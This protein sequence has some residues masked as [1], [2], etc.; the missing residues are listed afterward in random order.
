[1]NPKPDDPRC[2]KVLIVGLR[3]PKMAREYALASL[4]ELA[5]LVDTAGGTVVD[6]V[7][8]ELREPSPATL[9]GK[10]KVDEIAGHVKGVNADVVI[11]DDELTPAQ[12]RNLNEA[13]GVKVL[14]RTAL[15]LDI[16][17][18]RAHTKEGKLQV[19]LAQ[20]EYR[21]PRLAGE[22]FAMSQQAGY[23]GNRGPG[24]TKLEVDRR[25]LRERITRL[26]HDLKKVMTHR[27]IHRQK[28]EGVPIPTISLVGYTNAGK[29]TLLNKLTNADVFVEDKLFATLDPTVRR[30]TLENGREILVADTVGFIRRLPHQLVDSF[31]AT[32]EEVSRSN[33]LLHIVDVSSPDAPEQMRTVTNVLDELGLGK[34][35]VVVVLNKCDLP[36]RYVKKKE[37]Y[38][39][40]SACKG[41]GIDIL[42]NI[43]GDLLSDSFKSV[44]MKI[45]YQSAGILDTL[46]RIGNVRKIIKKPDFILLTVDIDNKYIGKYSKYILT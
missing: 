30:L 9:I 37:G 34:K 1:M 27:E 44:E 39:E 4:K 11:L 38:V 43:V 42:L 22:G 31:K 18:K 13:F 40:I 3:R 8:Q 14:D 24:E 19:E 46:Y 28:R 45:P 26:R 36:R 23:I 15:I 41:S 21:L 29:S 10:G 33:L 17:A 5:S 7:W 16:F 35:P 12:N 32:F 20:L 6:S 25:R 2:E